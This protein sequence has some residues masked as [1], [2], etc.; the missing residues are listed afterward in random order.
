V[1]AKHPGQ[2]IIRITPF[3]KELT[4][5]S[6]IEKID[7]LQKPFELEDLTRLLM[8]LVEPKIHSEISSSLNQFSL[9][10]STLNN[11]KES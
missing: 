8:K 1:L 2:T 11:L 4:D 7:V 10:S 6:G 9:S 5:F 3:S